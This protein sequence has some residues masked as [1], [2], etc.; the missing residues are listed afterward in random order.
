[1][2]VSLKVPV[3]VEK[4]NSTEHPV[5]VGLS[6]AFMAIL[7]ASQLSGTFLIMSIHKLTVFTKAYR[8][9]LLIF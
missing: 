9:T 6:D 5:K 7:P 1:M 8:A 3:P 2:A 4:I